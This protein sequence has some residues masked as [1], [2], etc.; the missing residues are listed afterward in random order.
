MM[1]SMCKKVVVFD[2]DDTLYKEIDFLKSGY[3]K[4][5]ELVEK[6]F[7]YDAREVYERL[8]LWYVNG[9]NP[10]VRLNETYEIDN[11]ISDYLD[12]YRYHHPM[13]SLTGE[14]KET[15]TKLKE[16]GYVLGIITDGREKTQKQKVEALGLTE[17]VRMENVLINNDKNHFKPN[18]WGYDRMMM[19][20]Y[21]QY[22]NS[23]LSFCYV[24]DNPEKDFLAPNQMGW[25]S[26]CLEDDHRNIHEQDFTLGKDYLPQFIAKSIVELYD[27]V[28]QF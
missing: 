12:I 14:T 27:L 21:R 8:Y 24:G 5:A 17:W 11:P 3:R 28:R 23:D 13:I 19:N 15:L 20:C 16:A 1:P 6:R 2:L 7:H 22:P 4:V 18:Q 9:E 10:F 25:M 26:I